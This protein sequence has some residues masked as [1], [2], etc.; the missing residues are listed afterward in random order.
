MKK[1]SME[2]LVRF[3]DFS[4]ANWPNQLKDHIKNLV[5]SFK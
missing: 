1:N 4:F 2:Q 3:S 5:H